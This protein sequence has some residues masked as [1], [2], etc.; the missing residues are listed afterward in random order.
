MKTKHS[1]K[2]TRGFI[3]VA[4]FL[5]LLISLAPLSLLFL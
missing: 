1:L 5:A 3:F 4:L 2:V